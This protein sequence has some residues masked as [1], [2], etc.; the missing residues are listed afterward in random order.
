[1]K[2]PNYKHLLA[3]MVLAAAMA[4]LAQTRVQARPPVDP[5]GSPVNR[6]V[7]ASPRYL[8]THPELTRSALKIAPSE[9][10]DARIKALLD[11]TLTNRALAASPR[12]REEHPA[13]LRVQPLG[14]NAETQQARVQARNAELTRNQALATSPRVSEDFPELA[15]GRGVINT[16]NTFQLAPVK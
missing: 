1:M 3:V 6:A 12:F 16:L 9:A 7:A 8:E 2:N 15:R 11:R 13:L 5:G 10:K 14:E 4:G